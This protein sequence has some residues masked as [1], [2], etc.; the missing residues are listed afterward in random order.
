MVRRHG[1]S[2]F[3]MGLSLPHSSVVLF[4]IDLSF[5]LL[6]LCGFFRQF[7]GCGRPHRACTGVPLVLLE[8]KVA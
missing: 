4:V 7:S 2:R 1:G 3:V 8:P 5:S 6:T